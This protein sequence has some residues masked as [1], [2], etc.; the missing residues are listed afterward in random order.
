MSNDNQIKDYRTKVEAKRSALG[1][2]PRVNYVTNMLLPLNDS[3][4]NLNLMNTEKACI[5]V[6]QQLAMMHNAQVQANEWLGTS[7]SLTVGNFKVEEWVED[8]R[9]RLSIINW[10]QEKQKLNAMDTKL[11]GLL[12]EDAK[13]A[14]AIADIAGELGL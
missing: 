4:L 8:I 3:K 5:D 6:A 14:N 9:T 12:S 13:T 7:Q 2:K 10:D 11:A 1:S